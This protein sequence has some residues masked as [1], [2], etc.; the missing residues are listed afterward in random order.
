MKTI[1]VTQIDFKYKENKVQI[2]D[3]GGQRYLKIF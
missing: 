3:V 1:G 2:F